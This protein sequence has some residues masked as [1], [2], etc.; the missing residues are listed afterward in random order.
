MV[1]TEFLTYEDC[2]KILIKPRGGISVT[3]GDATIAVREI[4]VTDKNGTVLLK[5]DLTKG[6][7]DEW[8]AV[9]NGVP[10]EKSGNI[11]F[12]RD[13]RKGLILPGVSAGENGI[14]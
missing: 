2:E 7:S 9:V 10:S 14:S 11:P 1:S 8:T 5:E 12:E 4:C 13:N 6:I 3:T